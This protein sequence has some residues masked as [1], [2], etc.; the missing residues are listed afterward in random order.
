MVSGAGIKLSVIAACVYSRSVESLN[1]QV[2][3]MVISFG[4]VPAD[5]DGGSRDDDRRH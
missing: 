4:E 5:L 2:E 3:C 1:T